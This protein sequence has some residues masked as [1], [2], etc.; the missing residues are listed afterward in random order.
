MDVE[1]THNA[2]RLPS[3]VALPLKRKVGRL[4]ARFPHIG[5]IS[6][7]LAFLFLYE[8]LGISDTLHKKKERKKTNRKRMLPEHAAINSNF[9][10]SQGAVPEEYELFSTIWLAAQR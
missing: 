9:L 10:P 2:M 3:S 5:I 8:V 7:L 4:A 1:P 6:N